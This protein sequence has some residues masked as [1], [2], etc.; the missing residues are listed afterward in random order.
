MQRAIRRNRAAGLPTGYASLKMPN[1]TRDY[2]PKL[3]AMKNIVANP[4]AFALTL[5]ALQ[6]HPY[7]LSVPI[8]RDMDVALAA[9][10]AGM[11]L[12]DFQALNPQMNRPVILA[13]GTPQVLLPYDNASSF[14]TGV[15]QHRGPLATWTAWVAPKTMKTALVAQLVGMDEDDLRAVNQIPPRMLVKA[16]S[17]LLVP[18][19]AQR[20]A[21]VSG[22]VADSA[23]MAL[24]P[25]GPGTK[26]VTFRAG[27]Q[28]DSV[29]AVAKR[30]RVSAAQVAGWNDV[31]TTA[32]FA[33]G[34]TVVVHQAVRAARAAPTRAASSSK[35]AVKRL[36]ASK[37]AAKRHSKSVKV[38]AA[39]GATTKR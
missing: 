28:G 13:S 29:A 26:R 21:D 16:G 31:G 39:G 7:F 8:A 18:R 19:S 2:V 33:A 38:A 6:N 9:K 3:Q 27:K 5:P 25:D 23:T 17:T 10:L 20:Q 30:Y 12:T 37:P 4:Q 32:R 36:A 34:S 15:E 22:K 35:V 14:V 1:E 24:A 11:S